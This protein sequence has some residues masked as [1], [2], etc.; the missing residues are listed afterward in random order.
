MGLV[1]GCCC[2]LSH[3]KRQ[4]RP[5]RR[6]SPPRPLLLFTSES[7]AM[8]AADNRPAGGTRTT[9]GP[10]VSSKRAT[11]PSYGFGSGTRETQ[12][13]VFI[14]H[15][16]A[17][18][19][20]GGVA[21]SP[22]PAVY[23]HRPSV[24]V[25]VDG[26]KES[27]PLWAFGTEERFAP[28]NKSTADNPAPGHHGTQSGIGIQV[29]SKKA[30]LPLYGF[31]SSTRE[32]QEKVYVDQEHSAVGYGKAS[33]GPCTYMLNPAV[34]KQ[35]LSYGPSGFARSVKNGSQPTWV[36][37]KAERLMVAK[38]TNMPG[39]GAYEIA[40]A[41][42]VQASSTKRSL[43]RFGFG[44]STRE[45]VAKVYISAEHEKVMPGGRDVPG[46]GQYPA[47]N[48]TG[49]RIASSRQATG[50]AWGFGTSKRF[51]DAS[52]RAG[53]PGPGQYVI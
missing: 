21:R 35:V 10:Q 39:P 8:P 29:D 1:G 22:G 37:G 52:K 47:Q 18:L 25:Q 36:F 14:S 28:P 44:T 5:S 45:N 24:G 33:P 43:P 3:K 6:R 9:L 46:P 27:A 2:L 12:E 23:S 38:S 15:E 34:G 51:S 13:R 48:M 49:S 41:V 16:H 32:Q 19:S 50:S 30:S 4:P 7:A 17:S 11:A 31:G 40:T 53:D 20:S 26:A 42:G